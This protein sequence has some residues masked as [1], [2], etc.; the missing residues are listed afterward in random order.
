MNL[1]LRFLV[2]VGLQTYFDMS[3]SL[4]SLNWL[5]ILIH[6]EEIA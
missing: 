6:M 5:D 3:N 1:F 4:A 2:R